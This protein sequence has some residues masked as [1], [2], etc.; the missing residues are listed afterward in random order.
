MNMSAL[1]DDDMAQKKGISYVA[2][3]SGDKLSKTSD[4]IGIGMDGVKR[5]G[6]LMNCLPHVATLDTVSVMTTPR[7]VSLYMVFGWRLA[8]LRG[9][10]SGRI[11]V[12]AVLVSSI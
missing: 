1:Y 2:Y 12:S 5:S 8:N 10:D 6:A 9:C 4:V 3:F 11:W 7:R